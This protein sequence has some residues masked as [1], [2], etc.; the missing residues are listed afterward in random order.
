[1]GNEERTSKRS[2]QPTNSVFSAIVVGVLIAVIPA[3]LGYI[4]GYV[5]G[6]RKDE[7]AFTNQQ[8]ERLYG[9]LYA[10]TQAN[11][12]IWTQFSS[13][14]WPN[15][16]RYYFDP[17]NPPSV[18]QVDQWRIWMKTVFQPLN[19]RVEDII[20]QNSQLLV[21]DRLPQTFQDVIA[22]AEAYKALMSTWSDADRNNPEK[23]ISR[24][25]NTI[26]G[27]NYP[28]RIVDCVAT[29]YLALKIRQMKLER[30]VLSSLWLAPIPPVD[31]CEEKSP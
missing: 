18:E 8:I 16:S 10:L 15:T 29:T 7:L 4:F 1:M 11:N 26:T 22:Q 20:I 23:Y 24:Y 14:H 12:A 2:E 27:I 17:K 13:T 3:T 21:G 25:A 19:L 28:K 9:P 6:L 31:S 5:D 30:S